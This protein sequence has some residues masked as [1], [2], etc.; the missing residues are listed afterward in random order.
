MQQ[1]KQKIELSEYKLSQEKEKMM[2]LGKIGKNIEVR[3]LY[4]GIPTKQKKWDDKEAV[5]QNFMALFVDILQF[6]Q[7]ERQKRQSEIENL[8]QASLDTMR[9][10]KDLLT[11]NCLTRIATLEKDLTAMKTPIAMKPVLKGKRFK[12]NISRRNKKNI[13]FK[14]S[15]EK[16]QAKTVKK[17]DTGSKENK[18]P[19]HQKS[20]HL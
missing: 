1:Y 9:Q 12:H 16:R 20:N 2:N 11:E 19:F 7:N 4:T 10:T 8:T 18:K 17:F 15:L 6:Y 5:A 14:D 13:D 3:A